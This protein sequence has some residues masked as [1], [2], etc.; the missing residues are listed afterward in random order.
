MKKS[1]VAF[2]FLP[3]F[4]LTIAAAKGSDTKDMRYETNPPFSLKLLKKTSQDTS[5]KKTILFNPRHPYSIFINYELG[6]HCVGFDISY[7]CVIPPYNS[8]QAQAFR[9]GEGD[10]MPVLLEPDSGVSLHYSV[11]DNSYSEGNK[12]KYWQVAKDVHGDGKMDAPGD[13]MANYVWTHL[14]IYKDLEGTIPDDWTGAK[15]LYVGKDVQVNI[16]SGPTGKSLAGGYLAYSGSKGG[17]KVFTDSMV[18]EVKNVPLTLT[19][20]YLWDALGLPL[21]AFNDSRRKGRLGLSPQ[22]IFSHISI[23]W[24]SCATRTV[25]PSLRR[26]NRSSFSERTL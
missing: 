6:M 23:Q 14:F 21:T 18:P 7:C 10:K 9:T 17:N 13:S 20:S 16:D 25:K 1:V 22:R 19:A 3:V 11:R 24:S 5:G 15:R 8:I 26:G 4:L 2:F 12:M